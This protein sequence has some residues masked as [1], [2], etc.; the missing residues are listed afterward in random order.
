MSLNTKTE[1][2]NSAS[3]VYVSTALEA[4]NYFSRSTFVIKRGGIYTLT[5][6]VCDENNNVVSSYHTYIS[7]SYSDEYDAAL[8]REVTPDELMTLLAVNGSGEVIPI[9]D[10]SGI[11]AD[12][13]TAIDKTYDPRLVLLII[14]IILF[15]LDVA[16]RKFKFKWP[17]EIIRDRKMQRMQ[18]DNRDN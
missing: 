13:V 5:L 4:S 9:D 10:P 17:H 15:L 16:V 2:I 14:A 11:Y 6:E 7:F 12:F 8:E 1:E 18:Q 3:E